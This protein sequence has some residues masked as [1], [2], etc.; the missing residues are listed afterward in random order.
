VK[1]LLDTHFLLWIAL[2]VPRI[3]EFPWLERYRPWGVSPVSF[4][5]VQFL[6]EVGKLEAR[7]AEFAAAIGK[8]SRFVVDEVPLLALIDRAL[9]LA[10]TRDPFDRLLAAH[11]EAR[12]APLCTLDRR[13][14]A[15][16][17]LIVRELRAGA[18]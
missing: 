4:L 3:D 5:E 18:A 12:R 17:G 10:W 7:S 9:P 16:H 11:S 1:V 2:D 13:M 8:D 14:R 6:T 15:E